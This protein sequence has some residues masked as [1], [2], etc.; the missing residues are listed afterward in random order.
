MLIL[1]SSRQDAARAEVVVMSWGGAY[2][3]A[4]TEA[5]VKPWSAA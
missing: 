2:G 3:E 5:H 1:I 4:Q